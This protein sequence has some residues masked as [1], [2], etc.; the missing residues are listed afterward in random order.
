MS[1]QVFSLNEV[2]NKDITEA[3]ID[4]TDCEGNCSGCGNCCP[5]MLPLSQNEIQ[6]IKRYI[7]KYN[8]KPHTLRLP[9]ANAFLDI[10]CPFLSADK[11]KDR[12]M[13]Y[14]VRPYICR[15]FQCNKQLSVSELL[16]DSE[17]VNVFRE[18]IDMRKTFFE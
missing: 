7:K 6:V 14:H 9:V 12:C 16:E 10:T 5:N 18:K 11:K 2:L 3:P 13:I 8:I 17:L 1:H 4:Y 15:V